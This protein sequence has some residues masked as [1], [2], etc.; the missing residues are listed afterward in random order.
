MKFNK[1]ISLSSAD[2][3]DV[4]REVRLA[5]RKLRALPLTN[6]RV[7]EELKRMIWEEMELCATIS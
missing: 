4:Y 5:L 1:E 7:A 2:C 3:G 6:D